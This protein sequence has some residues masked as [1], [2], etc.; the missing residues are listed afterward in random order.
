[1]HSWAELFSLW[2]WLL[3]NLYIWA[4]ELNPSLYCLK[5]Q[6]YKIPFD[7]CLSTWR[8]LSLC[9]HLS[10]LCCIF[11]SLLL[12]G[13]WRFD[14]GIRVWAKFSRYSAWKG[15]LSSSHLCHYSSLD[16]SCFCILCVLISWVPLLFNFYFNASIWGLIF[17]LKRVE[18]D[19]RNCC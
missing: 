14:Q 17:H 15:L 16:T 11:D 13:H 10:Y 19:G 7:A 1:M 18:V 2:L 6:S 4:I 8:C 9:T 5:S 12:T 3:Q